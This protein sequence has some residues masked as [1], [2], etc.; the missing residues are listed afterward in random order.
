PGLP[1]EIVMKLG[2]APVF[3]LLPVVILYLREL[4]P[5]QRLEAP[6][7][8]ARWALLGFSALVILAP[9]RVYDAAFEYGTIL[10]IGMGLWTLQVVL[11]TRSFRTHGAGVLFLISGILILG[12][13]VSDYLREIS[14]LQTPELL[15]VSFLLLVV[16]QAAELAWRFR[17]SYDETSRLA[18]EVR[19]LN[20]ELEERIDDRTR[21]LARTN[22]RLEEISRKDPLTG[23]SNR[24]H[25]EEVLDREW[26]HARL[27]GTPLALILVDVDEFKRFNDT[28]G[29]PAGDACLQR[30]SA[31]LHGHRRAQVDTVA[32]YGGEEFIVFLPGATRDAAVR[33][34]EEI[35]AAVERTGIPHAGS[36]AASVVTVSAGVASIFPRDGVDPEELLSAADQA[37][38]RAK[39]GGRNRVEGAP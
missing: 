1:A 20:L 12:A 30:V 9:L 29:H 19:V 22:R 8:I 35:R 21:E 32:R 5:V 3:L 28:Y 14:V 31:I 17:T 23:V 39:A 24:R 34:A 11:R 6:A 25:F 37:L 18:S 38:Y 13:A 2:Y 15:S 7:R 33:R 16:I 4:S 27:R 26:H 36:G 10:L